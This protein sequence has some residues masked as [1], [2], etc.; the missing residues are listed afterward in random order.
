MSSL[1]EGVGV[2]VGGLGV[3]VAVGGS[4]VEVAVGGARVGVGAGVGGGSSLL[5]QATINSIKLMTRMANI[6]ILGICLLLLHIL[7]S[8]LCMVRM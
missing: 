8:L 5:P 2:A 4:G 7:L 3:G 6:Q 1:T